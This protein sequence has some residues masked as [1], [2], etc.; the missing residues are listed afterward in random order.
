MSIAVLG[1]KFEDREGAFTLDSGSLAY[2]DSI[3]SEFNS[4]DD[5]KKS[6]FLRD[7]ARAY[8]SDSKISSAEIVLTYIRNNKEKK[9]LNLLFEKDPINTRNSSLDEVKSEAE[10]ARKLLFNSKNQTFL[11]SFLLDKNF[12]PTI[13][14]TVRMT[15]DEYK[16]AKKEGYDVIAHD[17]EYRISIKDVLKYRLNHKKL[18]PMRLL[19]EDTLE[20]W[21]KNMLNLNDEDLYFY[22]RELRLMINEYNDKKRPKKTIVN[23]NVYRENINSTLKVKKENHFAIKNTLGLSKRKV[24]EERRSA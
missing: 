9:N 12:E 7:K 15:I 13:V 4:V 22:S 19:F 2:I 21:K 23:F 18:G 3:T 11:T 14:P 17:G 24:L 6:D 10:K 20:V 8:V 16:I 1:I 5:L